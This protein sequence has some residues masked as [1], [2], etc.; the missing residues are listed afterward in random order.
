MTANTKYGNPK[1]LCPD[2]CA[3]PSVNPTAWMASLLQY[4]LAIGFVCKGVYFTFFFWEL[5]CGWG[6][7]CLTMFSKGGIKVCSFNLEQL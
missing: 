4:P 2:N 5:G 7:Q 1:P 6:K 3:E